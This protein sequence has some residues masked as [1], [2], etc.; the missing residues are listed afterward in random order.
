MPA[1]SSTVADLFRRIIA[2]RDG[3]LFIRRESRQDKEF[4]NSPGGW[5]GVATLLCLAR[6]GSKI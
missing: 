3:N 4:R 6:D 1:G 2:A 5:D